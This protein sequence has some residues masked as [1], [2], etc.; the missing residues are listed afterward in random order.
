MMWQLTQADD[1][2]GRFPHSETTEM[3]RSIFD[4]IIERNN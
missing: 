1:I 2:L 4:F 3:L